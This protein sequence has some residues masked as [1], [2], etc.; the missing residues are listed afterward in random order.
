MALCSSSSSR[1]TLMLNIS[2]MC[3]AFNSIPLLGSFSCSQFPFFFLS[4]RFW[5]VRL[6][7]YRCHHRLTHT[8]RTR[9]HYSPPYTVQLFFLPSTTTYVYLALQFDVRRLSPENLHNLSLGRCDV[10]VCMCSCFTSQIHSNRLQSAAHI[11]RRTYPS[12]HFWRVESYSHSSVSHRFQWFW[13][14]H[15]FVYSHSSTIRIELVS[16]SKCKKYARPDNDKK[17]EN[18]LHQFWCMRRCCDI[19]MKNITHALHAK[20]DDN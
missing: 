12:R 18:Y 16:S 17:N 5:A 11:Q 15:K 10:Y 20:R 1:H 19:R 4:L 7:A 13:S 8:Q 14:I 9:A 2:N 3:D 6:L